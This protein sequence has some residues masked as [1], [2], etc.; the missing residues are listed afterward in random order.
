M[1][2][3]QVPVY[4]FSELSDDIKEKVVNRFREHVFSTNYDYEHILEDACDIGALLGFDMRQ[5]RST[6]AKTGEVFCN[7]SIYFSGFWSQG[8]GACFESSYRYAKKAGEFVKKYTGG[9]DEALVH[10]AERLRSLQKRHFYSLRGRT[11]QYGRYNHAYSMRFDMECDCKRCGGYA[12]DADSEDEFREICADFARWIYRR[13]EQEFDYQSSKEVI[14][15]TI[16]ANEYEF[17]EDGGI[18]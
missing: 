15:E 5:S 6:S 9:T 13:L 12:P 3:Q 1:R 14:T 17:Y 16:E 11:M 2:I 4:T 18:A 8:D 7:K 10:I